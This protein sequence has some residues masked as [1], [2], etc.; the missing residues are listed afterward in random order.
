MSLT[1]RTFSKPSVYTTK[2]NGT[3]DGYAFVTGTT[4]LTNGALLIGAVFTNQTASTIFCGLYDGYGV[5]SSSAVPV[6]EV[7]VGANSQGS[8]DLG[9]VHCHSVVNG[10]VLACS[11]ASGVYTAVSSAAFITAYYMNQ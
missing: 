5:P 7:Q 1:E 11:S 3:F 8:L 6:V 4:Q 2:G 9:G 10:I